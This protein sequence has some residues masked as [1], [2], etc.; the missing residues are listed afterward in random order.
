M[1]GNVLEWTRSFLGEYPYPQDS[2]DRKKREALTGDGVRV[3]RGGS[4]F[5]VPRGVRCACRGRVLPGS[6]VDGVGFRLAL[7]PFSGL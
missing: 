7:A 3:V 2:K 5:N 6:R 1:S 4:Y